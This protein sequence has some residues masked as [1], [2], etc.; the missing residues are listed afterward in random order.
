[1]TLKLRQ[2]NPLIVLMPIA[3]PLD[4]IL[5]DRAGHSTIPAAVGGLGLLSL[6]K[7][8]FNLVLLLVIHG[9]GGGVR[10]G[11]SSSVQV[12]PEERDVEDVVDPHGGG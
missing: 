8:G 11:I 4:Q 9:Q 10:V 12:G 6:A 7:Q 2:V 5:S 3:F 1:M